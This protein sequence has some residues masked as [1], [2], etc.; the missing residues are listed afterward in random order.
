[1][2]SATLIIGL[3][4][5]CSGPFCEHISVNAPVPSLDRC[6]TLAPVMTGMRVRQADALSQLFNVAQPNNFYFDCRRRTAAGDTTVLYSFASSPALARRFDAR[7]IATSPP[8]GS[9]SAR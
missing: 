2:A 8:A 7:Q 1:M 4:V 9:P 5:A 3:L 6:R